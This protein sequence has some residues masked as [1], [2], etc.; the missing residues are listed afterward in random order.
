MA[1]GL[2]Q[3]THEERARV[4]QALVPLIKRHMGRDLL[5]LATTGS[6][7]RGTD[8][9]YSDIE[10]IGFVRKRQ[11]HDRASVNFIYDGL[12]ID[13]WFLT[14]EDYL[15]S[16]RQKIE[17]DWVFGA[18]GALVPVLN[19]P[20]IREIANVPPNTTREECLQELKAYWPLVQ[21]ATAKLLTAVAR[22][23]SSPIS[24]L[25]WQMVDKM[26]VALS[27]VNARPYSTRA[28]VIDEA[29]M[30]DKVPANFGLLVLPS[31][32][33]LA[34]SELGRRASLVFAEMEGLLYS[35][36]VD[37]YAESLES[38]VST[39]SLTT[40]I[41]R[42]LKIYRKIKKVFAFSRAVKFK[43]LGAG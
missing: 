16:H 6:F 38:F 28:A 13:V 36:G 1:D 9:A 29:L 37:P 27:Y 14:R 21:E 25:Y 32:R 39:L 41:R 7:A 20:Y 43:L 33:V 30:F 23:D 24:H 19:E 2:R 15:Y 22:G 10:L 42:R 26:C 17:V 3:H 11:E 8:G 40:K 34:P 12:L 35:L 5:A 18:L 31:D 4:V